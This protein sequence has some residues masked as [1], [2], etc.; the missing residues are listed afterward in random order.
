MARAVDEGRARQVVILG[1]PISVPIV[2]VNIL[3]EVA[4]QLLVS[5]AG[6]RSVFDKPPLDAL[7]YPFLRRHGRGI[8]VA[9]VFR[10][11]RLFPFG[12]PVIRS[13]FIPPVL[14]VLLM[15][16]GTGYLAGSFSA[17]FRPTYASAVSPVAGALPLGELP[18]IRWLAIGG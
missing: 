7:A 13:R 4:G 14:G 16:A 9:S 2:Y 1:A 15:M 3:N 10:G 5:G 17:L 18:I 12:M 6:F 11:L 8:A